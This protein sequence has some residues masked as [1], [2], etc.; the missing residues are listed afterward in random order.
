MFVL[1]HSYCG[2]A[3]ALFFFKEHPAAP[4]TCDHVIGAELCVCRKFDRIDLPG[5]ASLRMEFRRRELG[6]RIIQEAVLQ[7]ILLF[8]NSL[9]I[10]DDIAQS[11]NLDESLLQP[12]QF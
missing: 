11:R 2:G 10:G 7:V 9:E 6:F 1:R 8:F 12:V 3:E 4:A 5:S